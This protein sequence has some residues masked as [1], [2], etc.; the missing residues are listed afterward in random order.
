L[1]FTKAY[2]KKKLKIKYGYDL[3]RLKNVYIDTANVFLTEGK[4]E[5][6][7]YTISVE[8]GK[9]ISAKIKKQ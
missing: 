3:F 8:D 9:I 7:P 4:D 6:Y 2:N 1:I 5:I